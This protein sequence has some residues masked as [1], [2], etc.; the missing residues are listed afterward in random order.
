M[1]DVYVVHRVII[2]LH[3]LILRVCLAFYVFL[4]FFIM[5]G[6]LNVNNLSDYK[7]IRYLDPEVTISCFVSRKGIFSN[8]YSS[9][10]RAKKRATHPTAIGKFLSEIN[11]VASLHQFLI[12]VYPPSG[13][14][15]GLF[16]ANLGHSITYIV[17]IFNNLQYEGGLD[18]LFS[19]LNYASKCVLFTFQYFIDK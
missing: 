17:N 19:V 18:N 2:I 9:I 8:V 16:F 14:V 11:P 6:E 15:F 4:P 13:S 10:Y 1:R 5:L 12:K 7:K 3:L